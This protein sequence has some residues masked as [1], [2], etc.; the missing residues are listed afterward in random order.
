MPPR[1]IDVLTRIT[2]VGFEEAWAERAEVTYGDVQCFAIGRDAL[3]G[4][5]LARGR[6]K[7]L[8]DVDLLRRRS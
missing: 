8:V 1:R 6:P 5:K 3:I 7:D 2:E 4:N